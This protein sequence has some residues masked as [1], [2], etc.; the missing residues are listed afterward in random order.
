MKVFLICFSITLFSFTSKAAIHNMFLSEVNWWFYDGSTYDNNISIELGDTVHFIPEGPLTLTH[1]I[2]SVIIPSGAMSVDVTWLPPADTFLRYI[3]TELGDYVFEDSPFAQSHAMYC[4]FY[5]GESVGIESVSNLNY[6][7][8]PNPTSDKVI[9]K[10]LAVEKNYTIV[11]GDG[12]V[13]QKGVTFSEIDMSS[14]RSGLYSILIGEE[15]VLT[16]IMKR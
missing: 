9:I 3:P 1:T 8:F 14:L 16:R 10:G 4:G 5:V 6:S 11:S 2:T 7:V 15:K 13:V 12:K